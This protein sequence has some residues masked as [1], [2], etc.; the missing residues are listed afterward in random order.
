MKNLPIENSKTEL[1]QALLENDVVLL[2]ADPGAGKTTVVPLWLLHWLPEGLIYIVEPRRVAARSA[3]E[4][5]AE[6]LDEEVGRRVGYRMR[7]DSCSSDASRI[8]FVTEGVMLRV[9]HENPSLEGVAA[10]VLDEFHERSVQADTIAA[11]CSSLRKDLYEAGVGSKLLFMSATLDSDSL[12]SAFPE[13]VL[14]E[15]AGRQ[16]P[17]DIQYEESKSRYQTDHQKPVWMRACSCVQKQIDVSQGVLVFLPGRG[18]IEKAYQ[19]LR[20]HL[21]E[22]VEVHRMYSSLPWKSLQ[23]AIRS[24]ERKVVLATNIAEASITIEGIDCVVDGGLQR[25]AIWNQSSQCDEIVTRRV[26]AASADQRAGRAGRLSA[27]KCIRLWSSQQQAALVAFDDPSIFAA[28]LRRVLLDILVWGVNRLE[29]IHWVDRPGQGRIS[30]AVRALEHDRMIEVLDDGRIR[31]IENAE[32]IL[33]LP[34]EPRLAHLLVSLPERL[35]AAGCFVAACMVDGDFLSGDLLDGL[36]AWRQGKVSDNFKK[37]Y[38]QIAKSVGVRIASDQQEAIVEELQEASLYLFPQ[39][40]CRKTR[41]SFAESS[42]IG[43]VYVADDVP[44][45]NREYFVAIR[46]LRTDHSGSSNSVRSVLAVGLEDR[47]AK[48]WLDRHSEE[49]TLVAWDDGAQKFRAQTCKKYGSLV[50]HTAPAQNVSQESLDRAVFDFI[51]NEAWS[52]LDWDSVQSFLGR[53]GLAES[54]GLLKRNWDSATLRTEARDWLTS[55][56]KG[57]RTLKDIR[58]IPIKKALEQRLEWS[59]IQE[60][61]RLLPEFVALPSG[62]KVPVNYEATSPS[63]SAKLQEFFGVD[64]G[65]SIFRGTQP[66]L[67]NLLS[68]AG[69]PL[70]STSDLAAFWDGAYQ[71]VRKEM[72]GRYPKHPWP[73]NPRT[74]VASAKTKKR[75]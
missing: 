35:K 33:R 36:L 54:R 17:V 6:L 18:E 29:D 30:W 46:V 63:V 28:D 75:L 4:R 45:R 19:H 7:A 22:T 48:K 47:S 37:S 8:L 34:L 5:V 24:R 62:R 14:V 11:I 65:P 43:T 32:E 68:P 55:Y 15:S 26:S 25:T 21:C 27:G 13:A 2:R 9:L 70:Q 66:L 44:L 59:E 56:T 74:A 38:S 73:E 31:C 67:L 20:E 3:A 39:A 40:V 42:H 49:E 12:Y 16:F 64:Q 51:V 57:I 72:R 23:K 52:E 58:K 69:R 10:V 50:L 53:M 60:C 41:D 61:S 1:S 71:D